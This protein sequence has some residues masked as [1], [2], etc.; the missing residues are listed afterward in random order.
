M[1]AIDDYDDNL[2]K[3]LYN[4]ILP[5]QIRTLIEDDS[6]NVTLTD[7]KKSYET[8]GKMLHFI[9]INFH[10][11]MTQNCN[12]LCDMHDVKEYNEYIRFL[13]SSGVDYRF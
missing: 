1:D 2:D 3:F 5:K 13:D 9:N 8:Y 11:H 4:N 6:S 10:M 7:I 12:L